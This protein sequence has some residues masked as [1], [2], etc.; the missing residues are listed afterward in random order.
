V[1][2][3]L[4]GV[5][6]KKKAFIKDEMDLLPMKRFVVLFLGLSVVLNT[7]GQKV[8]LLSIDQMNARFAC[9]KD[10]TYVIH[11]WATWCTSCIKELPGFEKLN[12]EHKNAKVKVLLVSVDFLSNLNTSVKPF[13]KRKKIQSDVFL[14]N[15]NDPQT[16]ID[17]IAKEWSGSIP[18]TL[19]VHNGKRIFAEKEFTYNGLVKQYQSM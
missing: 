11:F 19:F 15:E 13:I 16:Y 3:Y 14:L 17:R 6:N 7:S 4:L 2:S 8:G 9:G 5:Q 1:Y 12:T 18:A 10:T